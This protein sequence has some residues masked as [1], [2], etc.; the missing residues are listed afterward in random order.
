MVMIL[1]SEVGGPGF[2]SQERQIFF[3]PFFFGLGC[4]ESSLES[5]TASFEATFD[6]IFKATEAKKQVGKKF[7]FHGI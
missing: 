1:G 3:Q 5:S 6:I 2:K 7:A 4:L